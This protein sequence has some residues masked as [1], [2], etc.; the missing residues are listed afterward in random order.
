MAARPCPA[1][2]SHAGLC[3]WSALVL[4]LRGA[5]FSAGT[6]SFARLLQSRLW[7]LRR[8][9][10]RS[11][12]SE[13]RAR[14][15]GQAPLRWWGGGGPAANTVATAAAAAAACAPPSSSFGVA[16]AAPLGTAVA[17][18]FAGAPTAVDPAVDG[19]APAAARIKKPPCD[20][21]TEQTGGVF[22]P[23]CRFSRVIQ[24]ARSGGRSEAP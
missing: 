19:T 7:Q 5:S 17:D 9:G 22:L 13:E 10:W 12:G 3:R 16:A 14:A 24:S 15:R 20:D 21:A 4:V 11:G 23:S 1:S 8:S 2:W 18:A 6:T